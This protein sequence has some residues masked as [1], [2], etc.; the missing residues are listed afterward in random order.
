MFHRTAEHSTPVDEAWGL[1]YRLLM[2][3]RQR[4]L[5]IATELGLHPAQQGALLQMDPGAPLSMNEL[6]TLL[7]C[8]SSNVTG[9]VDRLEQR[10]LVER[11]PYEGDRRVKH[12]VLTAYG[13]QLRDRVRKHMSEP[14]EVLRRLAPADQQ[15]LR[16]ILRRALAAQEAAN[17]LVE[18]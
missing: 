6:A 2:P 9:I 10:G 11:R 18:G 15:A 1:L 16:D 14:P 8:D 7:H 5:A 17:R 3:Q 13:A 12:V 4:F